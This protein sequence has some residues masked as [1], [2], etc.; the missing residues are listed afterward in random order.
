VDKSVEVGRALKESCRAVGT[1][2]IRA[3]LEGMAEVRRQL[4]AEG[5][6]TPL[7]SNVAVT[8]CGC[9][10]GSSTVNRALDPHYWGGLRQVQSLAS[11][12]C[13]GIG[14]SMHSTAISV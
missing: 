6:D 11:V 12:R 8:C 10:G 1:W 5:I 7:A 3:S 2:K 9:A 13:A 4:L 14:L